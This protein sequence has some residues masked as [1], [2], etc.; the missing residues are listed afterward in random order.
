MY[1]VR[2]PLG[3]ALSLFARNQRF[4]H[5]ML[6]YWPKKTI[7]GVQVF[8]R[9]YVWT[10][11][12]GV[13]KSAAHRKIYLLLNMKIS[14][15]EAQD[16]SGVTNTYLKVNDIINAYHLSI[17][18]IKD[19]IHVHSPQIYP[20]NR[21][22]FSSDPTIPLSENH[23]PDPYQ[24]NPTYTKEYMNSITLDSNGNLPASVLPEPQWDA[25]GWIT[26]YVAYQPVVEAR[27]LKGDTSGHDVTSDAE[28]LNLV[29]SNNTDY[30]H[31]TG[32]AYTNPIFFAALKDTGNVMYEKRYKITQ[33]QTVKK[34]TYV[35]TM[36]GHGGSNYQTKSTVI[37]Q[38]TIQVQYRR[39]ANVD[40]VAV[41]SLLSAIQTEVDG[42]DPEPYT[43][44]SGGFH[45]GRSHV[46]QIQQQYVYKMHSNAKQLRAMHQ[47]EAGYGNTVLNYQGH[48]RVDGMTNIT[49]KA[50]VP[51][52]SSAIEFGYTEKSAK[53][54]QELIS[55]VITMVV[56]VVVVVLAVTGQYW[57][58]PLALS[59]GSLAQSGLAM[60]WQSQGEYG[61]AGF[62]GG[63][64]QFLGVAA[65]VTGS[66][67][68][69]WATLAALAADL[70]LKELGASD[71]IRSVV[72]I[73]IMMYV[74][75]KPDG[76]EIGKTAAKEGGKEIAKD[77]SLAITKIVP[78]AIE[79]ISSE[80]IGEL[81]TDITDS[82]SSSISNML[83]RISTFDLSS[84]L[85]Q[86][87]ISDWLKVLNF[88]F[89]TFT[90]HEDPTT[91]IADKKAKIAKQEAE[92]AATKGPETLETVERVWAS[93][94]ENWIDSNYRIERLQQD[95]TH[96]LNAKLMNKY[97]D[98]GY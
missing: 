28:L 46:H 31:M 16:H 1:V 52:F 68:Q 8:D 43:S 76:K 11:G 95:M 4:K 44:Y 40:D 51:L 66:I 61:A 57:A 19:Y 49:G 38:A 14:E 69:P 29:K 34:T 84:E 6:K 26:D 94:Y 89:K 3:P 2:D 7:N 90:S 15:L 48:L 33:K 92:L 88:A 54:W 82:I 27:I 5:R 56:L 53:W 47:Y 62:A 71:M 24:N 36:W 22:V 79:K 60:Y 93:P 59:I 86:V 67:L 96:G 81:T 87:G 78:K 83:E 21:N 42:L 75:G 25:N 9:L 23:N 32:L 65:M 72:K 63:Q 17:A 77:T 73:A 30:I 50:F 10:D 20:A 91:A 85:M 13:Q 55:I 98:S 80:T 35:H 41:A 39:I 74:G 37:Q 97:F 64:A 70:A 45:F 18:Q 58:I 12:G